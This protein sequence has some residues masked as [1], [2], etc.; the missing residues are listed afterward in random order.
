VDAVEPMKRI[1]ECPVKLGEHSESLCPLHRRLDAAMAMVEQ[2]FRQT[3]MTQLLDEPG[4]VTPF[5]GRE[6]LERMGAGPRPRPRAKDK[7]VAASDT[8]APLLPGEEPAPQPP[9]SEESPTAQE[10]PS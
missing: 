2:L 6:E 7:T 8:T 3:T 10:E 5:C 9:S 4:S 1:H